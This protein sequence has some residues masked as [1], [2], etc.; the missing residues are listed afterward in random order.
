MQLVYS[1]A[2][3]DWAIRN[4]ISPSDAV[5]YHAQD[6]PFWRALMYPAGVIVY[7]KS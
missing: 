6:T 1:T 4:G 5:E 7:S 3:A 2:P